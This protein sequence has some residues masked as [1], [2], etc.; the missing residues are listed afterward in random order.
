MRLKVYFPNLLFPFFSTTSKENVSLGI[1]ICRQ[2]N[3]N[4]KNI[5]LQNNRKEGIVFICLLEN[6]LQIPTNSRVI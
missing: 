6:F 3:H 1:N 5:K 4:R 2:K